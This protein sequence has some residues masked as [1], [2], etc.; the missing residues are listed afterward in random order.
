[1]LPF[2][3]FTWLKLAGALALVLA[4]AAAYAWWHHVEAQAA[5]VPGLSQRIA[6]DDARANALA[7]RLNQIATARATAERALAAWQADKSLALQSL[8]KEGQHASAA[9]NP[10]CAPSDADRGLRNA[11][12]GR[13]AGSDEARSAAQLP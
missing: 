11:T 5:L 9:T 6:S 4:L 2:N 3:F 7:A 1:M 10:V 8:E 13:L 12:L